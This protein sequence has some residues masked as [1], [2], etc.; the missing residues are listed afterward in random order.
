[1]CICC[2]VVEFL[3][4]SCMNLNV[5]AFQEVKVVLCGDV[6]MYVSKPYIPLTCCIGADDQ[7]FADRPQLLSEDNASRRRPPG[8]HLRRKEFA[9]WRGAYIQ[10]RRTLLQ[11]AQSQRGQRWSKD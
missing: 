11:V 5:Q 9:A 7:S 1:M 3:I 10:L 8:R 2:Y 4:I 6:Q